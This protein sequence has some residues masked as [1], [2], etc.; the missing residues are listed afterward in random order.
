MHHPNKENAILIASPDG[1]Y[2]LWYPF[3]RQTKYEGFHIPYPTN[4]GWGLAKLTE[5]IEIDATPILITSD[6]VEYD[7]GSR[8]KVRLEPGTIHLEC[9][10]IKAAQIILDCRPLYGFETND[11]CYS[12]TPISGKTVIEYTQGSFACVMKCSLPLSYQDGWKQV[13]YPHDNYRKSPPYDLWV[14]QG[15]SLPQGSYTLTIQA[16]IGD[17]INQQ[18]CAK[19]KQVVFDSSIAK[20]TQS[21]AGAYSY[22]CE[23]LRSLIVNPNQDKGIYAGLPWFFQFW[24]RDES[25]SL[26]ALLDL[27]QYETVASILLRHMS[28]PLDDGRLPNRY[29]H[30][31]LGSA[32]GVGWSAFRLLQLL[33]KKPEY[34]T[35]QYE[36]I[37]ESMLVQK[38][39]IEKTYMHDGLIYNKPLETWV[40]TGSEVG[41][42]RDGYCIEI[43][44]LHQRFNDM[45][46][47][48]AQKIAKQY[49]P[50]NRIEHIRKHFFDGLLADRITPDGK[51]DTTIRSNIFLAYYILPDLL[52]QQEWKQCFDGVLDHLWIEWGGVSSLDKKHPWYTPMYAGQSNISYHRGDSWYF[53]NNMAAL[54]LARIDPVYYAT[55]IVKI[56]EASAK[57]IMTMGAVGHHAEVSSAAIQQSQGCLAQAWSAALYIEAITVAREKGVELPSHTYQ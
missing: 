10:N 45:L 39:R 17:D 7:D 2:F 44:C 25:I 18:Q 12:I 20:T 16:S 26:G 41:D 54:S 15:L 11:R 22:A 35:Q 1:G 36:S 21:P 34:L 27:E 13:S 55:K 31:D 50:V 5:R 4:D 38:E 23:S 47:C 56:I 52:S 46:V 42:L 53:I 43:Q 40:D 51:K 6:T 14:H 48:L 49:H 9:T 24:T 37:Y 28:H 8:I 29:P 33:D 57:E 30:S 19:R 32:D 3:Q